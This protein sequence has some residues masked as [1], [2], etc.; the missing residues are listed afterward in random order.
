[1]K[2]CN[3]RD[4]Q[5]QLLGPNKNE[6]EGIFCQTI[7]VSCYGM[8][9]CYRDQCFLCQPWH[10]QGLSKKQTNTAV[11]FTEQCVHRFVNKYETILNCHAVS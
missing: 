11:Q 4:A 9:P 3:F 1:M 6:P 2:T 7:P 5:P 8:R 10:Q